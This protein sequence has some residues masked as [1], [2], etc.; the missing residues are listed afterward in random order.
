[1]FRRRIR[2]QLESERLFKREPLYLRVQR[3]RV[4]EDARRFGEAG[5]RVD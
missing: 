4:L 3:A 2:V 1:M 5:R